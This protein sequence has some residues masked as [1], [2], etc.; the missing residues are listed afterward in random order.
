MVCSRAELL[1]IELPEQ[2]L[3]QGV[4]GGV[5]EFLHALVVPGIPGVV[6]GAGA[7]IAPGFVDDSTSAFPAGALLSPPISV[8]ASGWKVAVSDSSSSSSMTLL[9]SASRIW[10]C[11]SMVGSRSRRIACWSCGVIVSD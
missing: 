4:A 10:A 3:V 5:G 1:Q 7:R 11:N 8:V 6:G 2:V 9:S